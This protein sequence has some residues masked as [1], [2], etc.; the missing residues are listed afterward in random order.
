MEENQDEIV[1]NRMQK[2]AKCVDGLLPNNYGFCVL[3]FSFGDSPNRE[4]MYA[5]NANRE[6]IVIAMK[7]WIEKTESNYANDTGKY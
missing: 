5:S 4:M 2:I 3:A 6:D 1:K 7:E